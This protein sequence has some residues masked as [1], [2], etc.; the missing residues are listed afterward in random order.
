VVQYKIT[1]TWWVMGAA[2]QFLGEKVVEGATFLKAA[3]EEIEASDKE[4]EASVNDFHEIVEK[5]KQR[6]RTINNTVSSS[7]GN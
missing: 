2:Y 7:E 5:L 6:R 3:H 4:A 1:Q